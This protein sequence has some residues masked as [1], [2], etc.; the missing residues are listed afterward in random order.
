LSALLDACVLYSS[1]LRDLM[2]RLALEEVS[3]IRWTELIQTEWTRNVLLNRPDLT[4]RQLKR[5]CDLMNLHAGQALVQGFE[6]LIETLALPDPKDRHVLAAAI[7]ARATEIVTFN[8]KDFP[9]VVLGG[10]GIRAIDPDA[11]VV[12]AINRDLEGVLRALGKQRAQLRN[13]PLSA[14]DFL[15]QLERAGLLESTRLL[16]IHL[17]LI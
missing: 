11:F 16:Q 7:H 14:Q 15:G 13:P 10:Y 2:M 9:Q 5:V 3:D 8:L 1:T 4:L 6:P 17:D 12:D